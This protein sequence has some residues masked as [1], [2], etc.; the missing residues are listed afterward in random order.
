MNEV[1]IWFILDVIVK[2]IW[3]ILI[4]A[5]LLATGVY[6][7]NANFV[8]PVYSAASSIIAS[9]GGIVSNDDQDHVGTTSKIGSSDISSSLNIIDTYVDILKTYGFYETVAKEPEIA[10]LGYTPSQLA[11]MTTIQK[12]SDMSLFIDISIRCNSER[13]AIIIA[14]GVAVLAA[15]YIHSMLTNAYVVR[16]DKCQ[17]ARL[18]APLTVRNALLAGIAGALAII[19]VFVIL[20]ATDNTIKGED[21]IVK[22]YNVPVLGFVPDFETSNSKGAKK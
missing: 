16:A 18:V 17:T 19:A 22:K 21:D 3:I 12:R 6:I 11:A 9:N 8:D 20:A 5:V 13:D 2:R 7:Y 4:V 15:D 10:K 1:S 14:N